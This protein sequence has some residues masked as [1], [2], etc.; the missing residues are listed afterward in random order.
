MKEHPTEPMYEIVVI[1]GGAAGQMAALRSALNHHKTIWFLGD[2]DTS[3]K[4]RAQWVSSVDNIPG[5]FASKRPILSTTKET[6]NFLMEKTEF[7]SFIDIHKLTVKRIEKNPDNF[8]LFTEDQ[9]FQA[10]YIILCTGTM[11]VQPVIQ[12]SIKPILPFA[13]RGD[14][15]YCLRCDGHKSSG[16]DTAVIG[17]TTGA[18]W[19]AIMLHERYAPPTMTLLTHGKKPEF[20]D[21]T[22]HLIHLYNIGIIEDE[23]TGIASEENKSL[24]GF[25]FGDRT[26]RVQKAFVSLGSIVYNDL[27]KGLGVELNNRDHIVVNEKYETSVAN[28]YAAGDLVAGKK[29]QVYTAWDMAVDAADDIDQKIRKQ[30]RL[31]ILKGA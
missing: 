9:S 29:K 8:T 16:K 10:K 1:G 28:F 11:D 20:D 21:E 17:H 3:R 18:A 13:N 31:L 24:S 15:D 12:G 14:V 22:K 2:A 19:V 30:K 23:I 7:A 26:I 6:V 4:G 25:V 5:F 27:A